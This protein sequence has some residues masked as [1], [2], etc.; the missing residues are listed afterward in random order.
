M[1]N[2]PRAVDTADLIARKEIWSIREAAFLLGM[3]RST[4]YLKI[5]QG[6]IRAVR[7]GGR[8]YITDAELK[9][10][11]ANLDDGDG[12]AAAK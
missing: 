11:I 12:T 7:D 3:A 1:P 2:R 9:R 4:L 5:E 10:Y 8:R 6:K